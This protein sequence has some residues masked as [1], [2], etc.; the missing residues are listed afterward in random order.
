MINLGLFED[1]ISFIGLY[2]GLNLL[3][4]MFCWGVTLPKKSCSNEHF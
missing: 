1:K 3:R 2:L 4:R